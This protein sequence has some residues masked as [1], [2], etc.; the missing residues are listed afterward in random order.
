MKVKAYREK[1][2][3]SGDA[4]VYARLEESLD[5]WSNA[6]CIGYLIRAARETGA[7]PGQV[8]QMVQH[9][10]WLLEDM[11]LEEAEEVYYSARY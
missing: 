8:R 10:R 5:I 1:L 2:E 3:R 7:R 11:T 4:D 9:L 6:A